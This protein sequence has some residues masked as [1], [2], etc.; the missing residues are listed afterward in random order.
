MKNLKF[1]NVT[2]SLIGANGTTHEYHKNNEYVN[3]T[4]EDTV[5]IFD[6]EPFHMA[7]VLADYNTENMQ[8]FNTYNWGAP[9]TVCGSYNEDIAIVNIH[10]DGDVRSNYSM[11]Y[12]C[13]DVD[14]L[15]GQST[16]LT[17]ELTDGQTF[18]FSCDNGEGYF[19]F[20]TFDIYE[21]DFN[22]NLTPEQLKEL[23][24]KNEI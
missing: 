22:K 18:E 9:I 3:K 20:N 4:V 10:T 21:I 8:S 12:I 11:P 19:D 5:K 24:E 2:V 23:K 1:K 14:A 15:L 6:L 16:F 17:I 13:E 7:T